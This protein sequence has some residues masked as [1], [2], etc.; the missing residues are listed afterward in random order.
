MLPELINKIFLY[1]QS[2]TN[3]I[4]KEYI[5]FIEKLERNNQLYRI[6]MNKFM[7]MIWLNKHHNFY[8]F[9]YKRLCDADCKCF[10]IH[11]KNYQFYCPIHGFIY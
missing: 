11:L 3:K 8:I 1:V 10:N 9:N 4:I 2:P 7:Y 5:L 6:K